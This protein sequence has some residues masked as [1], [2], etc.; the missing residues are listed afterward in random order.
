MWLVCYEKIYNVKQ[1]TIICHVDYMKMSHIDSNII[2]GLLSDIDVEYGK[3]AKMTIMRG[4]I[5]KYL[6]MT[7]D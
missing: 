5:H 6:G 2:S 7:I 4:K 3:I 1:C